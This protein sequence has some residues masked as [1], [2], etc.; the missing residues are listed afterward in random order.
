M[1][2]EIIV[3]MI[4][5]SCLDAFRDGETLW[6][7]NYDYN[8]FIKWNMDS[9]CAEI[10]DF[11]PQISRERGRLHRRVFRVGEKLYF[12]PFRGNRI[13]MESDAGNVGGSQN[14]GRRYYHCGCLYV[15]KLFLD[16][17]EL[18]AKSDYAV[19]Y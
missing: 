4:H 9:G 14:F 1:T 19:S 6:L 11:F 17:S 2:K 10:V 7:S 12:I 18:S 15:G 5:I 13:H 3:Y 8:A 16:L